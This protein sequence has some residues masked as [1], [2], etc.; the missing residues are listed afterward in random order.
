MPPRNPDPGLAHPEAA[1]WVLGVLE[2]YQRRIS[3]LTVQVS[4][5]ARELAAGP[6]RG[7]CRRWVLRLPG[8]PRPE[9]PEGT[10][11]LKATAERSRATGQRNQG[12]R[13]YPAS[14]PSAG[15]ADSW[16]R[17]NSRVCGRVPVICAVCR[18][19]LSGFCERGF[20]DG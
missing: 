19:Q 12:L 8:I 6:R 10:R 5:V 3:R 4:A 20:Q 13:Y 14:C 7:C 2:R 17:V 11:V 9:A 16:K 1:G 18:I 15:P